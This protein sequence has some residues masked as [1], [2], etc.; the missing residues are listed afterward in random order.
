MDRNISLQKVLESLAR[1]EY[2]AKMA[3]YEIGKLHLRNCQ[4]LHAIVN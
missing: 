3:W 2:R 4:I 1:I